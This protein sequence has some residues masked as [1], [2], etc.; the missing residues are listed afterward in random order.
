MADNVELLDPLI[1]VLRGFDLLRH[2]ALRTSPRPFGSVGF[3]SDQ[4]V[5]AKPIPTL[6]ADECMS[7]DEVALFADVV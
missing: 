6:A 5:L 1:D 7:Q 4:T 3:A 2:V